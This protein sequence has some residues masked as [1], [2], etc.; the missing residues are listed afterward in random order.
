[1]TDTMTHWP[2]PKAS[3][4][5]VIP[6]K[7]VIPLPDGGDLLVLSVELWDTFTR[8][9]FAIPA[10][11]RDPVGHFESIQLSDDADSDYRREAGTAGLTIDWHTEDMAFLGTPV[12]G[13]RTLTVS[14]Q[15]RSI[16]VPLR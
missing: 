6:V 4:R 12:P 10:M 11:P 16:D 15:D 5:D 7:Q 8:V 3:L 1:M 14:V 2:D 9:H 13:A